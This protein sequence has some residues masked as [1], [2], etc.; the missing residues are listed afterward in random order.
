MIKKALSNRIRIYLEK[1]FGKERNNQV[2]LPATG[3]TLYNKIMIK[4]DPRHYSQETH[5]MF[6]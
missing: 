6:L 2:C 5:K 3:F 4:E 1:S